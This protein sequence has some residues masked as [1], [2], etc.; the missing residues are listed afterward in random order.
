M[1]LMRGQKKRVEVGVLRGVVMVVL[2]GV[3]IVC[4]HLSLAGRAG[5]QRVDW[6]VGQV[7]RGGADG[8]VEAR[9]GHYR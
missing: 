7:G 1:D 2:V 5:R 9:V 4:G 6:G 8:A 3:V